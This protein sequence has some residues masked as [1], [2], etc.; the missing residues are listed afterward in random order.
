M[1][2][3]VLARLCPGK[4]L[5]TVAPLMESPQ[6]VGLNL[7]L[8]VVELWALALCSGLDVQSYLPALF[9]I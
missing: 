4:V 6:L 7:L 2:E 3:E 5:A 1:E 8:Q 9:S